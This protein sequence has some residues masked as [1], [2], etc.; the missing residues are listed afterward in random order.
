M[1]FHT[2]NKEQTAYKAERMASVA[3]SL[4]DGLYEIGRAVPGELQ[5]DLLRQVSDLQSVLLELNSSIGSLEISDESY[6]NDEKEKLYRSMITE[7]YLKQSQ[8]DFIRTNGMSESYF[9]KWRYYY[10]GQNMKEFSETNEFEPYI[11]ALEKGNNIE[12][13]QIVIQKLEEVEEFEKAARI[14]QLLENL[15]ALKIAQNNK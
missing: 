14:K 1:D 11:Q 6:H 5:K 2:Q 8:A 7:R 12:G 15:K 9:D 10:A 3:L 4:I 13:I